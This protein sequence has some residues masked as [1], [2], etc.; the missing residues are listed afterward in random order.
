MASTRATKSKIYPE[1]GIDDV[2]EELLGSQV[3]GNVDALRHFFFFNRKEK[4]SVDESYKTTAV[5]LLRR[6]NRSGVALLHPNTDAGHIK[7]L[8]KELL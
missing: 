7:A 8:H 6:W 1:F 2:L 3:L 4:R 5:N